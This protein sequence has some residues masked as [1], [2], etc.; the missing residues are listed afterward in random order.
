[1]Q[2]HAEHMHNYF[3]H[4]NTLVSGFDAKFL[5]CN[6]LVAYLLSWSNL[7]GDKHLVLHL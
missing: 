5:S 7:W 3:L 1:M 2:N 4:N 6:T